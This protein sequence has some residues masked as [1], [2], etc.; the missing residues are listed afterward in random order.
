MSDNKTQ[1]VLLQIAR[2]IALSDGSIS[3]EEDR[4]LKDL[5]G[6]LYLEEATPDD[7]PNR[8]QSLTELATLLTNHTDQCTAVRVACLVAGV[9]R[10]PGDESDINPKERLAYRELIEALQVSDEELSEIQWAA[11]EELQQKRSLLNVILDAIYGKDG[12]P[13]QA[14]LPPDFPMI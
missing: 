10:N 11:K 5:P 6:R 9:S 14:L 4:L 12:W 8:P 1:N 13:D 3:D 7:R 2:C